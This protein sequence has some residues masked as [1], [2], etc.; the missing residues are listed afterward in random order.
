MIENQFPGDLVA[1]FLCKLSFVKWCTNVPFSPYLM[2]QNLREKQKKEKLK[3]Q[4][5]YI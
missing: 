5:R 4:D 3:G 2:P 1:Q